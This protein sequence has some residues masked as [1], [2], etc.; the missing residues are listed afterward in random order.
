MILQFVLA[1]VLALGT[2]LQSLAQAQSPAPSP[3]AAA[4]PAALPVDQAL[5]AAAQL[6]ALL[7][8]IALYPDTLLAQVLMA[9][10]YP[11]E[12]VQ[13]ERWA[14]ENKKLKGDA[15]KAAAE[16][17]PWDDS[18]KAL[19]ATP[20]V[21]EMMSK[22]LEWTQKL[23][24]AVL[25]QEPDVMDAVQRMR[26]RAHDNKKLT[27]GSQQTVTVRQ[28]GGK[29]TIAIAPTAPDTIYV[30]YYDPGVVYGA[31]PYPE[32][33]PYY[34]PAP[35]YIAAGVVA[36]GLAFGTAY[37]LGRWA[38]G[39]YWG[40]NI[41]W[42]NNNININR[43][44]VS[45]WQHNPQHRHGV[46]YGN[47]AVQQRFASTSRPGADGRMDFRGRDGNQVIQRPDRP[48][49]PNVGDGNR[50]DRGQG[51]NRP[52]RADRPNAGNRPNAGA[53]AARPDRGS[54]NR[55]ATADRA[56]QNRPNAQRP[57]QRPAQANRPGG[58]NVNRPAPRRDN[59]FG[60]MQPGRAANL[61]SQ[62][63][64]ASFAHAGARMGGG[65]GFGGGGARMGGGGGARMGGGGFGGGG[66]GGGGR[67]G[68][69]RRSDIALKD[70]IVELGRLRSGIGF[71][72]F[73]YR[74]SDRRYVGVM[75]QEVQEV[76][77]DAVTRGAD[78]FLRVYYERIGVRFQ[79]YDQWRASGSHVPTGTIRH[80]CVAAAVCQMSGGTLP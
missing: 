35:G 18:I 54:G 14:A 38:T 50:P 28:E 64:Q 43:D 40:G 72:R 32:S 57:A 25:A 23:G 19:V 29:Q 69:G 2:P 37:A 44:R 21:L 74:G 53:G 4:T 51:A 75:A 80:E 55:P 8:P 16:K 56:R 78:G 79:T 63:G 13:A 34:F 70:Q 24:D 61:Q 6:D 17:Q 58:G 65:G 36:T 62:R 31:W 46:R 39:G 33:P 20:S 67:G 48:D 27:S 52:D 15:L 68:G 59:A 66:R 73:A 5:L 22:N 49:R 42:N 71:Y 30:P 1:G 45:H 7:A 12:V 47:S 10:T 41:N 3:G 77:P 26:S 76:E 60:N 9:S 11:L